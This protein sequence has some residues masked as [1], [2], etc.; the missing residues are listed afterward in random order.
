M[1]RGESV[2]AK[3]DDLLMRMDVGIASGNF[4]GGAFALSFATAQSEKQLKDT[5]AVAFAVDDMTAARDQVTLSY[6][7][8]PPSSTSSANWK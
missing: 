6:D 7:F 8:H 1:V 4:Y 5:D 3:K 2:P